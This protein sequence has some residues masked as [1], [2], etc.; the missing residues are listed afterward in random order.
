MA[1]ITLA[2]LKTYADANGLT[3]AI[4]DTNGTIDLSALTGDTMTGASGVIEAL[5]KLCK[6]ARDTAVDNSKGLDIYAAGTTRALAATDTL[7]AGVAISYTVTGRTA[8][9][10]DDLGAV[11]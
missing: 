8:Y 6:L 7:P 4:D 10:L 5:I 9:S 1:D 2:E 3:G 11:S